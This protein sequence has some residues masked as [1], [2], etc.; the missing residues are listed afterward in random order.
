MSSLQR[1]SAP[2][3][4]GGV[5]GG[6][7]R[8]VSQILG[9]LDFE[10]GPVAVPSLDNVLFTTLFT[11]PAVA[12]APESFAQLDSFFDARALWWDIFVT[13]MVG[14]GLTTEQRHQ[15]ERLVE[16]SLAPAIARSARLS[17]A[18]KQD[19]LARVQSALDH[20][21]APDRAP[22]SP[23]LR[24][25]WK[26]PNTSVFLPQIAAR[27]PDMKYIHVIRHGLDMAYSGNTNQLQS[28][29]RLFGVAGAGDPRPASLL[30]FWVRTNHRTITCARAMLRDRFALV[31]FEDL[32]L[33]PA[34]EI[35]RLCEFL[36][37]RVDPARHE[38][39]CA[40]PSVPRSLGRYREQAFDA[41][42]RRLV[43][44]VRDFG[45]EIAEARI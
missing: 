11:L 13:A 44:S 40:I 3:V 32:V 18:R 5:G 34:D 25:G 35:T 27:F 31:R 14:G 9:A 4:V 33:R 19:L 29:G 45:F 20:C 21:R 30:E 15:V 12:R 1:Y 8:V 26:E 42:D 7:T 24:W 23:D 16:G 6:G 39:L 2:V 43:Q 22:V 17:E 28:W 37:I 41:L 36:E 10:L 38:A